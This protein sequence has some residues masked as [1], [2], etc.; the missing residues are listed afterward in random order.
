M[1][2]VRVLLLAV[3]AEREEEFVELARLRALQSARLGVSRHQVYRLNADPENDAPGTVTYLGAMEFE[4]EEHL[5]RF[6]EAQEADQE[7]QETIQ[8]VRGSNGLATVRSE[9]FGVSID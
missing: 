9:S 7:S 2:V 1:S 6:N 8:H 3:D 5:V 4:S